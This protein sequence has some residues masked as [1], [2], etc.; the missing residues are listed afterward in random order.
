MKPFIQNVSLDAIRKGNHKDP[1][2]NSML[3]Q[4]CDVCY[5]FP[6][7]S[8][9]FKEVHQF[10]FMD[11][12]GT[13]GM[14]AELEITVEQAERITK[15][16]KHAMDEGMNVIVHCHAGIAR[17][18]AVAEVGVIMGFADTRTHRQPNL[19]VKHLLMKSLGWYYDNVDDAL[20]QY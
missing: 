17:S 12:E 14:P 3:I 2:Q 8:F 6:Q 20:K 16:L 19:L 9:A 18:G 1:G 7:P 4:I 15:L 10:E 5:E 11:V 13:E